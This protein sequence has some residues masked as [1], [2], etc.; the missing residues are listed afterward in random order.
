MAG[1]DASPLVQRRRLR[2]ELRAARLKK[3]LTQ[4]QVAR[5]MEWS[6]SK[7]N[8][9]EKAK[10]GISANDLKALLPE[11]DITDKKQTEELLA[12]ARGAVEA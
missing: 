6:L 1:D 7:M 5:A 4:E 2:A 11:Y 10:T 9:I 8:R 12:L 3:G